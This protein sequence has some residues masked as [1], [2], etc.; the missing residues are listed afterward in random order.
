MLVL[1]GTSRR[2][3]GN[4][5]TV[6]PVGEGAIANDSAVGLGG[7]VR[8]TGPVRG[9]AVAQRVQTG[10]IGV[11]TYPVDPAAPFGGVKD[12]GLGALSRSRGL[13]CVPGGAADVLARLTTSGGGPGGGGAPPPPPP[14][15]NPTGANGEGGGPA[16][17]EKGR[18]VGP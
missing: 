3:A 16:G 10:A 9:Q 8:T 17:Q 11:N 5:V 12:S 1:V 15:K 4:T 7:S 6:Q 13:G 18:G 2:R 14:T